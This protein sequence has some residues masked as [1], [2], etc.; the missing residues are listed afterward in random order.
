MGEIF[1]DDLENIKRY[2]KDINTKL[3][4][5]IKGKGK[6]NIIAT[7][8]FYSIK[9]SESLLEDVDAI[10]CL[11]KNKF[12]N[13]YIDSIIRNMAEQVIEYKYIIDNEPELISIY[14]GKN[15]DVESTDKETSIKDILEK[16]K[17][18]GKARYG[19]GQRKSVS[20]MASEI[21]EKESVETEDN[22]KVSL[23]DIF[24]YEAEMEHNSYF[25][26]VINEDIAKVEGID[27][28]YF[29]VL[30]NMFLDSIFKSFFETYNNVI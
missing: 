18:S 21:V 20:S 16:L 4:M 30:T 23:Y 9:V 6:S 19:N 15:M 10:Y 1:W 26:S 12:S 17:E 11:K 14:F 27:S 3:N 28:G 25:N 13:R 22:I 24:S 29:N 2:I 5:M 8:E 7:P